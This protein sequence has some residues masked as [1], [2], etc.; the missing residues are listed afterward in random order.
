MVDK[1]NF[2]M[3][4]E[5]KDFTPKQFGIL[6]GS[7]VNQIRKHFQ[8]DGRSNIE[9][10]NLRDFVVMYYSEMTKTDWHIADVMSGIVGV[11][12]QEKW[13]RGMEV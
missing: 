10:Q 2:R 8:I 11:I 6:D 12:D 1:S 4:R 7:E 13:H 5:F 9:L 3:L